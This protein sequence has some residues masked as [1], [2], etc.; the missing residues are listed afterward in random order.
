MLGA[1]QATVEY[2]S[3]VMSN[4]SRVIHESVMYITGL[5]SFEATAGYVSC[6]V[7]G[8]ESWVMSHGSGS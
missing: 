3:L 1:G 2:E 7:M 8:H 5:R 4:E 6:G